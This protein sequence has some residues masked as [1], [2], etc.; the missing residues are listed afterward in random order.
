MKRLLTSQVFCLICASCCTLS[1]QTAEISDLRREYTKPILRPV[2]TAPRNT[3]RRAVF[4]TRN[5]KRTLFTAGHDKIVR[6]WSLNRAADRFQ[7]ELKTRTRWPSQPGRNGFI[8]AL[9]VHKS[10]AFAF[11]GFGLYPSQVNLIN[12]D[13][14]V[15]V[16]KDKRFGAVH[17]EVKS[18]DIHPSGRFMAVGYAGNTSALDAEFAIWDITESP[19]LLDHQALGLGMVEATKFNPSGT[20]LVVADMFMGSTFTFPFNSDGGLG[21]GEAKDFS[22]KLNGDIHW[23]DDEVWVA[24]LDKIGLVNSRDK[25]TSTLQIKNEARLSSIVYFINK[26]GKVVGGKRI[27]PGDSVSVKSNFTEIFLSPDGQQIKTIPR[28][29][30]NRIPVFV[31]TTLR[32]SARNTQFSFADLSSISTVATSSITKSIAYVDV[33]KDTNRVRLRNQATESRLESAMIPGNVTSLSFSEDGKLLVATSTERTTS[34]KDIERQVIRIWNCETGQLAADYPTQSGNVF[35]ASSISNVA[36]LKQDSKYESIAFSRRADG[37]LTHRLEM[38]KRTAA[39]SIRPQTLEQL[40]KSRTSLGFDVF[41]YWLATSIRLG[42]QRRPQCVLPFQLDDRSLL[43]VGYED[44]IVVWDWDFL[45]NNKNNKL[46]NAMKARAMVRGY[47]GHEAPVTCLALSASDAKRPWLLSGSS[48]GTICGWSL[49]FGGKKRQELGVQFKDDNGKLRVVNVDDS[50]PGWGAGFAEGQVIESL[51]IPRSGVSAAESV[52]R[53]PEDQLKWLTETEPG[54]QYLVTVRNTSGTRKQIYTYALHEPLFTLYPLLNNEWVVWTPSRHFVKSNTNALNSFG[55]HVNTVKNEQSQ[56]RFFPGEV[57][58]SRYES[59]QSLERAVLKKEAPEIEEYLLPS[60]VQFQKLATVKQPNRQIEQIIPAQDLLVSLRATPTS[61]ERI[62]ETSLWCNGVKLTQDSAKDV[63][64]VHNLRVPEKLLRH[65]KNIIQGVVKSEEGD[66]FGVDTIY[67]HQTMTVEVSGQPNRKLHFVGVGVDN[68]IHKA[69]FL[70]KFR[71]PLKTS[72]DAFYLR[73]AILENWKQNGG[74]IGH[75]DLLIDGNRVGSTTNDS[76]RSKSP[77]RENILESFAQ[78][79]AEA[80]ADD[81]V[82]IFL[83]GHGFN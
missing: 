68:L 49:D 60:H 41:D 55:W 76:I 42:R 7:L 27:K 6:H 78:L 66:V 15:H 56:V 3:I 71:T 36:I 80:S 45:T 10:G 33:T 20:K 19:K 58:A 29:H 72:N 1:A 46:T 37:R 75:D 18:L 26:A 65:G 16:L 47:Y 51:E 2:S 5:G 40:D 28:Q 9:D 24:A 25:K 82:I 30:P 43:A 44:G 14:S 8:A 62:V 50:G 79:A 23:T 73:Q 81:L 74:E 12:T 21:K 52:I 64:Q 48:D 70:A 54:L 32:V 59:V 38:P 61:S 34:Q 17:N 22:A 31:N 39:Q 4:L 57:F 63:S 69:E 35:E 77:T 11:G 13:G 83:A 67:G 53:S